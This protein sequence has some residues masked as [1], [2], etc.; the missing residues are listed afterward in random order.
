MER[1]TDLTRKIVA[2]PK[3]E[4]EKKRAESMKRKAEQIG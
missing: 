1:F 4:I 2:V 3:H